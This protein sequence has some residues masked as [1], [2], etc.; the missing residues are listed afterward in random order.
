MVWHLKL[1]KK[2]EKQLNS[3]DAT[4][5]NRISKYLDERINNCINPRHFGK[6]LS[7]DKSE[8]WCYRIGDYRVICEL[9]DNEVT[10]LVITIGHRKNVYLD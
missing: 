1:K 8:F 4:N 5:R 6:R 7:Y 2:A 10:I 9:L 3:L